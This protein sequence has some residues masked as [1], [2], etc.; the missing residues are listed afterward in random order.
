MI[1]SCGYTLNRD[2]SESSDIVGKVRIK[3]VNVAS[4]FSE[5]LGRGSATRLLMGLPRQS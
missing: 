4:E 5:A 1:S 2:A 3:F